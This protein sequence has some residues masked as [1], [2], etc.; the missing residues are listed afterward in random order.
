[1][2]EKVLD[3][4]RV[5]VGAM[6]DTYVNN[7][8]SVAGQFSASKAYAAGDYVYYN[9]KLYRFTAAH[10]AGAWT[11]SD[12]S[13]ATVSGEL[14]ALKADLDES[15]N[16]LKSATSFLV[17]V[18]EPVNKIDT[19]KITDGYLGQ[20]CV[21]NTSSG[22]I[23]EFI[24]VNPGTEYSANNLTFGDT[25]VWVSWM[26]QSADLSSKIGKVPSATFTTP[27]NCNYVR[28]V[29]PSLS[30][31]NAAMLV[32]GDTVPSSYVPYTEPHYDLSDNVKEEIED[33]VETET[34]ETA[35]TAADASE[36][37]NAV[38]IVIEPKNKVDKSTV[39][40]GNLG[41]NCTLSTS[42]GKLTGY[43]PVSPN[44]V[45]TVNYI[46]KTG[47]Y[48]SS[49]FFES[50]TLESH[51]SRITS[52]T[53]TTPANCHF[54]RLGYS[55][56]KQ[57]W[58]LMAGDS[59]PAQ[60]VPYIA[61]SIALN[62][63]KVMEAA[64]SGIADIMSNDFF[65]PTF[66]KC[67]VDATNH[68]VIQSETG[69]M[70]GSGFF[71]VYP[72]VLYKSQN[73]SLNHCFVYDKDMN[74]ICSFDDATKVHYKRQTAGTDTGMVFTVLDDDAYWCILTTSASGFDPTGKYVK[75]YSD[76]DYAVGYPNNL[77]IAYK[78]A[79]AINAPSMYGK[80]WVCIGDSI[81]AGET[82]T[83]PG[84]T[85]YSS[86]VQKE[87]GV[88]A[89]NYGIS[90]SR[91]AAEGDPG[92]ALYDNA[93]SVRYVDMIDGADY[94]TVFG[95][96]NDANNHL[97]LGELGDTDIYTFYGA[98]DTLVLGLLDKYPGKGIGF[99]TPLHYGSSDENLLQYINAIKEVCGKFAIPVLD[100]FNEGQLSTVTQELSTT[101][102]SDGLHPNIL[103]HQVM[104]RKIANF[105]NRL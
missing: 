49:W 29:Y 102:Y 28:L 2:S 99:I 89:Y 85:A 64:K 52:E 17:E 34:A 61:P 37:V 21:L 105:L 25:S 93:M 68:T 13:E 57:D 20:N 42:A 54:V 10:A 19:S 92:Q 36:M 87:C 100:M 84:F 26:F 103:G 88:I 53:F 27:N 38:S 79:L 78:T 23:T 5:K 95:G 62:P 31:A 50:E 83:N 67:T 12:A 16:D 91:I 7:P 14:S 101:Y 70:V 77:S 69:I 48:Y 74:Y 51:I 94:I 76:S 66:G 39:T 73:W 56:L 45:Y 55:T 43:I 4:M 71:R 80:K 82:L 11:G 81:T 104:A 97:P 3:S 46:D 44:T 22:K 33:I 32:E 98:L 90:G 72:Y 9:R 6:D 40:T 96:I 24:K 58:M 41:T 63:D 15:I 75:V 60:Y 47:N 35:E 65:D 30:S 86:L 8:K 1:M 59:I 18:V